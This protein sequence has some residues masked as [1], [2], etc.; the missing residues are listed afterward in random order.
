MMML[1]TCMSYLSKIT[2]KLLKDRACV[3]YFYNI[4]D[5]KLSRNIEKE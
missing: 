5:N 3:L 2:T 4:P 1:Y